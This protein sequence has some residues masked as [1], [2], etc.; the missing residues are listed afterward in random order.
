[1]N[2]RL[3]TVYASI[4][5]HVNHYRSDFWHFLEGLAYAACGIYHMS[6][7]TKDPFE[8]LGKALA[9]LREWRGIATQTEAA[10]RLGFD[11]GQLSRWENESPRPTLENLGR[12]L[13]AYGVGLADLVALLE[14]VRRPK[15]QTLDD[16]AYEAEKARFDEMIREMEARHAELES[17]L[18]A[19][20]AQSDESTP[21]PPAPP[22]RTGEG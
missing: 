2:A 22:P 18:K 8:G 4:N 17:R 6:M 14:E 9:R 12:L 16:L 21:S 15:R 20:E 7:T 10:E 19:L 13:V 11:K 3:R 1:L 5:I